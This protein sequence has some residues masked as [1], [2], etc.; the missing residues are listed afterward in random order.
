MTQ[1]EWAGDLAEELNECAD[2]GTMTALDVLNA[3]G[4]CGLE[5][6]PGDGGAT[7]FW[8]ML[9]GEERAE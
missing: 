2:A 5:L 7:G 4:L 3:L 8:E 9:I 6:C 1:A